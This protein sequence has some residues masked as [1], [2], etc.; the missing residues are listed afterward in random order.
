MSN[1]VAA[2]KPVVSERIIKH[3]NAWCGLHGLMYTDGHVTW[4]PAP[5]S[6]LP[7]PFPRSSFEYAQ[8]IQTTWNKLIDRISR[9]RHFITKELS[10]VSNADQFTLRLMN[11]Y[12]K[13]PEDVLTSGL[14]FGILRSDYMINFDNRPL[15][16]EINTISS[17]FG[18]LSKKVPSLHKFLLNRNVDDKEM[19]D[20]V[21][22]TLGNNMSPEQ[23]S[24]AIVE[25]TSMEKLA[26]SIA[27]AHHA[28]GNDNAIVLFVVQPNERNV[29][30]S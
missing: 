4:T 28:Y 18:C 12:D 3:I 22:K 5:L 11:M 16:V 30:I 14:Q 2:E 15:Q 20:L 26:S 25:N 6:L 7:N 1:F 24:D 19:K 9:D 13:V 23:L 8:S 17:S 29:S 10:S 21:M 27:A